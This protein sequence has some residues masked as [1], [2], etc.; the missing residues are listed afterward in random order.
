V[1]SWNNWSYDGQI[2][3]AT[4]YGERYLKILREQFK[5]K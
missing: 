2:E 4:Q 1:D 3:P 5:V